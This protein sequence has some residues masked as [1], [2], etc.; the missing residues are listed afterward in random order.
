[1]I[2]LQSFPL[3]EVN[4]LAQLQHLEVTQTSITN[5]DSNI[6]GSSTIAT[7]LAHTVVVTRSKAEFA[8]MHN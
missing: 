7:C 4:R 3:T 2:G 6:Q 8:I 1:M 5:A